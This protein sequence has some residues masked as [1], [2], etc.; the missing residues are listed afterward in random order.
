M[1]IYPKKYFEKVTDITYEFLKENNIQGLILD[2]DNT[3]LDFDLNIIDGLKPWYDGMKENG[4]K[5]MILSNSNK[6][7]KVKMVANLMKIPFVKF[8]TKPLKRG[9][10]I[11]Q[12]ILEIPNENIA[13][14]GDQI[15][16][17]VIGANRSKMFSILVKP[18]AEKDLL[19]TRFKRPIENLVIKNYLKK[20]NEENK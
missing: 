5:C 10:K 7:Q 6:T 3:L 20:V 9:F 2:V 8:A 4:I 12:K 19:I 11:A 15:F 16:T 18:I 14:V 1:K 17:D 13:V